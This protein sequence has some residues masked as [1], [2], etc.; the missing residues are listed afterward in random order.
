M[1]SVLP[2]AYGTSYYALSLGANIIL[3]V[4]IAVRLLLY[5]RRVL[6]TLP[7]DHAK[8]YVSLLTIIVESAALYSVFALIFLITYG[9]SHPSNQVFFG[10]AS[11]A[12]VS[13][14]R[15]ELAAII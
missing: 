7:S 11:A 6:K 5:R 1:Y 14:K 13:V 2:L 8:D 3:T 9:V 4:L 10:F 12:Q 15:L